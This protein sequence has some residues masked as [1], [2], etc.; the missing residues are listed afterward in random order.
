MRHYHLA[1]MNIARMV[2]PLDSPAMAGFVALLDPVNRQA[3]QS[4]GFVWR[5][6][7]AT[8]VQAFEDPAMLV[9]FSIWESIE[10][11]REFTYKTSHTEPLRRRGEWFERGS[12]ALAMWWI[13]AGHIPSVA[14]GRDRIEFQKKHGDTQIAFSFRRR[15]DAPEAPAAEP[16]PPAISL[17]NRRFAIHSA[18]AGDGTAATRFLYRQSGSRVLATYQGGDVRFGSLVAVTDSSGGLDMRY[19]HVDRDDVLRTGTCY[20]RPE[21]GESGR[22]RLHEKWRRT[23][24]QPVAGD[25]ILTEIGS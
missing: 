25:S 5:L 19:H 12:N 3:E 16:A 11:L 20:S 10:A 4:P 1:Q 15:F 23:G 21:I 6:Q 13:P 17:D 7:E 8:T 18:T 14:D 9:N 2:A 22:L 24:G